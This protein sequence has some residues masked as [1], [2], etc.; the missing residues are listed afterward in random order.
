MYFANPWGLLGLLALPAILV[1]HLYHRRYPPLFVAGTHLWATETRI[2]TPGRRRERLPVTATLLLELLAA[3]LLSLVLS[4]PRIGQLDRVSHLVVVLDNSASMSAAPAGEPENSF[5]ERAVAA[6]EKRF[7]DLPRGS[8]LT[9]IATGRRPVMLAGPAAPWEDV[10]PK[11]AEWR[12]NQPRHQFAPA[13][14]LARQLV[15]DSGELLFLTDQVPEQ[16]EIPAAMEIVSVGQPLPNASINAARWTFDSVKAQ[17]NIYV[18]VKNHGRAAVQAVVRG[19]AK[20]QEVFARTLSLAA[21][22]AAAFDVQVPGGLQTMEV[23]LEAAGDG[24]ALDNRVLLVEPKVRTVTVSDSLPQGPVRKQVERVLRALP[25]VSLGAGANAHVTINPAGKLPASGSL[26]WWLGVGPVNASEK[27]RKQAKDLLGPYLIEKRN[28][29]LEGLSLGGVVWGGAQPVS[30]QFS[31]LITAGATPLFVQL[32]GT[33]APAYLLNV[34][35]EKSNLTE[36]PDWPILLS[37][38]IELRRESLPGLARWNYRLG[39]E[40]RFRLFEGDDPAPASKLELIHPSRTRALTRSPFVELPL[41][42]ET[43]LYEIHDGEATFGQL[44]VNFFDAEESS[45]TGLKTAHRM[46]ATPPPASQFSLDSPYSWA[47]LIGTLLIL[48]AI[49]ADWFVLSPR[50][51]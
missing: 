3:L 19:R 46:P 32:R 44:A 4:E 6:L 30:M 23:A 14:D 11:L 31:P 9:V 1:I 35:L 33:S 28:P 38:L 43:G 48:A 12:P 37:N 45:L 8:V 7:A 10:Q 36:S 41:L 25:E 40:V 20:E 2:Q 47:I 29:L 13:W 16:Q 51:V 34:D 18:R 26:A 22:G 5:R 24:L 21:D 50:R 49:L 39:E 27:V 42:E 17:G 15:A